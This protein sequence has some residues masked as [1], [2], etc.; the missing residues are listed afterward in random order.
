MPRKRVSDDVDHV[1]IDPKPSKIPKK[2]PPTPW[3]LPKFNPMPIIQPYTN[4]AGDLPPHIDVKP[5]YDI[6]SLFFTD[7]ILI[8]LAESTNQNAE[9][10]LHTQEQKPCPRPWKPTT[11]GELRAW[12]A[13]YMWMGAF[14]LSRIDE[15]WN[16]DPLKGPIN[17][18]ISSHIS[19][20]R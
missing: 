15:Y 18:I 12:I 20:T 14:P 3:P 8:S 17:T 6:F 9:I 13:V 10:L 5:P 19:K 4:G 11:A 16:S 1:P 2:T 7:E